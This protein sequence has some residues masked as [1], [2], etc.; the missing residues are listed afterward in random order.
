MHSQDDQEEKRSS[1]LSKIIKLDDTTK[2]Q[3]VQLYVGYEYT[4]IT[5]YYYGWQHHLVVRAYV[6]YQGGAPTAF[7]V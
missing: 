4:V 5:N 2:S 6:I 3:G 7:P 1:T